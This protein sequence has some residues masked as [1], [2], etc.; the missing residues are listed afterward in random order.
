MV[1]QKIFTIKKDMRIKLNRKKITKI[2]VIEEKE[3]KKKKKKK[4]KKKEE[5][6]R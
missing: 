6:R 3:E 4:K 5:G 2:H 1:H